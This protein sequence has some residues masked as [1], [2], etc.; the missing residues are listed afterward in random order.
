MPLFTTSFQL[1]SDTWTCRSNRI[2]WVVTPLF[3][4]TSLFAF[5]ISSVKFVY[6]FDY[7]S[8]RKCFW[9]NSTFQCLSVLLIVMI[10]VRGRGFIQKVSNHG[11][12][13]DWTGA[14]RKPFITGSHL[15]NITDKGLRSSVCRT[16]K[17]SIWVRRDERSISCF[18]VTRDVKPTIVVVWVSSHVT[19]RLSHFVV[20]H[21]HLLKWTT[22]TKTAVKTA[23][24]TTNHKPAYWSKGWEAV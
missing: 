20:L 17:S 4:F 12:S 13:E 7:Y 18:D 19:A 9:G 6:A 3:L 15:K 14:S 21:L 1:C 5:Q 22:C 24:K 2:S 16:S 11:A 10:R 23:N 8:N